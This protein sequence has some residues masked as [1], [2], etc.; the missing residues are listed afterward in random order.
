V[1][2]QDPRWFKFWQNLVW[3]GAT[4]FVLMVLLRSVHVPIIL[5]ALWVVGLV[6]GGLL[7]YKLS[8]LLFGAN[9]IVV[10]EERSR[11]YLEQALDYKARIN[12]TIQE[13][14]NATAQIR[15]TQLAGQ[16]ETLT[17]AIEALVVRISH[18]RQDEAVRR[19]LQAVPQAIKDLEARLAAETD[20]VVRSQLERTLA[21]RRN[22]LAALEALQN[23]IKQAEIQV[24]STLS[25][26]GT[27][28]S[29]LLTGESTSHVAD[30][31]RLTAGVDEEV[32][33]LQDH[34]KALHEIKFGEN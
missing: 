3:F 16:I 8:R 27:I 10:S 25:Q 1:N 30:Y 7:A 5:P 26:L 15:L 31:G 33:L 12:Q 2:H 28:Y 24:E 21:N 20:V 13:T 9:Q 17:G 4:M 34:L 11:A 18:L 29:Q 22:Q 14:T 23:S 32:R 19:D 6:W